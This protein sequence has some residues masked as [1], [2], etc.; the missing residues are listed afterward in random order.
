MYGPRGAGLDRVKAGVAG[1]AEGHICIHTHPLSPRSRLPEHQPWPYCAGS[2]T[3]PPKRASPLSRLPPLESL[4]RVAYARRRPS[5][6]P[7]P[8]ADRCPLQRRGVQ[9]KRRGSQYRIL[10]LYL[11]P[12]F[13]RMP[14]L[15]AVLMLPVVLPSRSLFSY[16]FTTDYSHTTPVFPR[17]SPPSWRPSCCLPI[18]KFRGA[19]AG[20]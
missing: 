14:R 3:H 20:L 7:S 2:R 18:K 17:F 12:S 5:F 6:I 16:C 13:L 4:I 10:T 19:D 11:G 1:I 15:L 8:I 9:C